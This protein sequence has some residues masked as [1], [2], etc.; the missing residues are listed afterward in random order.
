M[1]WVSLILLLLAIP[2]F[3]SCAQQPTPAPLAEIVITS[4]ITTPDGEPIAGAT[5]SKGSIGRI[6][7][8]GLVP[9]QVS[10]EFHNSGQINLEKVHGKATVKDHLGNQVEAITI[11]PFSV[12]SGQV[13]QVE[14]SSPWEFQKPGIYLL[15]VA[16][17]IGLDALVSE[18]LAFR[19]TPISLPLSPPQDLEGEGL[20]TIPQQPVNWGIVKIETPLAWNTTHGADDIVVA[21]IDS[22]VDYSIFQL[23]KSMWVNE[24]EIPNNGVDDDR[25]GYIDDVHGWD[26]RDNDNDSLNGTSLHWHGTFVASIIAAWPSENG[27]VGVAPG[28]KIMD[29]RFLDSENLFYGRDWKTFAKAI[30]YAVDNGAR[31]INLSI[32]ADKKPPRDFE[33]AIQRASECGVI[34]VGIAGNDGRARVS[35]P[36]KY[37][38][39]ISVSATNRNDQLAWFSNY[40]SEVLATGPGDDITSLTPGGAAATFSGTSFSAPHVAGTLA[41]ILSVNPDLTAAQALAVLEASVVDLGSQGRDR[42]FGYGL[43]DAYR[44]VTQAGQGGQ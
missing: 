27:I 37:D 34:V 39:V 1:K 14:A 20:Y 8:D 32:Y 12:L 16:L 28:V 25:N 24:D 10:F 41:L 31:I 38:D 21:V 2:I 33:Q 22:G 35:Y 42:Q 23:A 13:A 7:I 15:Q 11:N 9:L 43:I 40:G 17:D 5:E 44:G 6:D 30:D 4:T 29:I 36:G 19:I 18:S 26:F 3:S